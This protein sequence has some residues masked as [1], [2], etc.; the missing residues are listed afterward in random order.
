M[1]NT[2]NNWPEA[3]VVTPTWMGLLPS[4]LQAYSQLSNL[5][6]PT[7]DELD[8][9][10]VLRGELSRMAR[11]A[12]M[13]NEHA[14]FIERVYELAFGDNAINRNFTDEEVLESLTEALGL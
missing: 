14:D 7:H 5:D 11:G 12:D 1:T 4:I 3:E 13:M 2:N 8:N 10:R 6:D 9:L